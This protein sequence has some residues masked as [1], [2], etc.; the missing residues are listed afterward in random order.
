MMYLLVI[1]LFAG[2]ATIGLSYAIMAL[3]EAPE[4][5]LVP[6]E[7]L[8]RTDP[9]L[10][11]LMIALAAGI[12]GAYVEMRR[13]EASLLPGVAI[14]VSLV[15]PLAAA[16]ILLYFGRAGDAWDAT[17]LFLVNLVAIVLS[18]CG[19]FLLLG[20]RPSMRDLG[21]ATRVGIGTILTLG[22]VVLLTIQ[23]AQVTLNRFRE[24]RLE[25]MVAAAVREWAGDEP[26]EIQRVDV[27]KGTASRTVE[28]WLILDV[29]VEFADDVVAP[30]DLIPP[31]LKGKD[32][33][34]MLRQTLGPDTD[35][36]F[37]LQFRYAGVFDLKTGE[38]IG[39]TVP[40]EPV[41]DRASEA[42]D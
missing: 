17:L 24:A 1:V 7:V 32:L 40:A 27:L 11:E 18:A 29:P 36:Q 9:G 41:S 31:A 35:I 14:G 25:G 6:S 37:R 4:G 19:V 33:K 5:M 30:G 42:S 22:I 3:A 38:Q 8:S 15:P 2:A 34:A 16:G 21:H 23:L 10:E 39:V 28:L 12:A 13:Q 20:I 26:V